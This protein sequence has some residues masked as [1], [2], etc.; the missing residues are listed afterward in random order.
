MAQYP[1]G[2]GK[3]RLPIKLLCLGLGIF[4][5]MHGLAAHGQ[6]SKDPLTADQEEQVRKVAD[7]PNDRVKLYIKFIEQRTEDIQ[8]TVHHP[9]TQHPGVDIHNSLQEFTRLVDEL[10]DNLDA[11]D[12]SHTDIRKSLPF[13]LEHSTKWSGVL[14]EPPPS[15]EY[16]FPR[17]TAMEAV[18]SLKD[19]AGSL[20]KS[21]QAY[22]AVH[23]PPKQ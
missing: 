3:L 5:A 11:Y 14:Q 4:A 1:L 17:K 9:A 16:D 15:E 23:K 10:Q 2:L 18:D 20:L 19:A 21:Q 12:E 6:Q 22:F 8:K 13:L 7:Q